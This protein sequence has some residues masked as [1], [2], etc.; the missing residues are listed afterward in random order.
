MI[1]CFLRYLLYGL[2]HIHLHV[3]FHEIILFFCNKF[4]LVN[5]TC[6][7]FLLDKIPIKVLK[8]F[9]SLFYTTLCLQIT[10]STMAY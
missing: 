7:Q 3:Y 6:I 8:T 1:F 4:I 10:T 9:K 2:F 5:T